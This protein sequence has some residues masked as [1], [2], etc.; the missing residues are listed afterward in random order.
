MYNNDGS[1]TGWTEQT[2]NLNMVGSIPTPSATFFKCFCCHE[3][4]YNK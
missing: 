3:F 1:R 4:E 2:V